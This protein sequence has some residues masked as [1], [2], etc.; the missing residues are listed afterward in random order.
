MKKCLMKID[1]KLTGD[2]PKL[3]GD[4]SQIWGNVS[5]LTGNVNSLLW[6]NVS[7]LTGDVSG[8]TGDASGLTGNVDEACLTAEER[9]KGVNIID[10]IQSTQSGEAKDE[11]FGDRM[12]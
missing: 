3:R 11:D 12:I 5:G 7:G 9:R 10:I 8:L 2:T 6:G 1:N 4:M